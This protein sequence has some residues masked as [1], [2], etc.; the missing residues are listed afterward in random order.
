MVALQIGDNPL[1]DTTY[2]GDA[3]T[4]ARGIGLKRRIIKAAT[5]V[6]SSS[7]V[8]ASECKGILGANDLRFLEDGIAKRDVHPETLAR[9][10]ARQAALGATSQAFVPHT[11]VLYLRVLGIGSDFVRHEIHEIE[12][13]G[14]LILGVHQQRPGADASCRSRSGRAGARGA[15]SRSRRVRSLKNAGGSEKLFKAPAGFW[16]RVERG[17]KGAILLGAQ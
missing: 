7:V 15:V 16:R 3:R 1:L 2:K 4:H 12:S 17:D 14:L 8:H 6:V 13:S 9:E 11:L 5:A 10:L